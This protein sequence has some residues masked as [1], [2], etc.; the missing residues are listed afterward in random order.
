MNTLFFT[1]KSRSNIQFMALLCGLSC[2]LLTLLANSAAAKTPEFEWSETDSKTLVEIELSNG[3]Q[4]V[5]SQS[6][7]DIYLTEGGPTGDNEVSILEQLEGNPLDK[8]LDLTP[9]DVPV[10]RALLEWTHFDDVDTAPQVDHSK[11]ILPHEHKDELSHQQTK[12]QQR[13]EQ[14][15]HA[16]SQRSTTEV[17]NKPLF[18]EL[19]PS[20]FTTPQL[21]TKGPGQGS[22][23]N[24]TGYL[25]FEENHCGTRGSHGDGS[26][27]NYC[28]RGMHAVVRRTTHNRARSTYARV[29][30]CGNDQAYI[31]HYRYYSQWGQEWVKVG[32]TVWIDPYT[33]RYSEVWL[34]NLQARRFLRVKSEILGAGYL[35]GWTRFFSRSK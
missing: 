4:I 9:N 34:G 19:D 29:A 5:F 33:W 8:F 32:P 22:C 24:S 10:P 14:R 23:N 26:S 21:I 35:R 17:I 3:N 11:S 16:L 6:G 12:A 1:D 18:V 7:E 30:Y 2:G 27:E 28:D 15:L 13:T 31:S 25:Y 20:R